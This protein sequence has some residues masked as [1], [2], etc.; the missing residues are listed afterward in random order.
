M[1][2]TPEIENWVQVRHECSPLTMYLRLEKG[3]EEDV[4]TRMEL[5]ES[6]QKVKFWID[7]HE[8]FFNVMREGSGL[9]RDWVQFNLSK[10]SI[11]NR[12]HIGSG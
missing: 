8:N 3:A 11:K 4:K 9:F 10:N 6:D 12:A 7:T 2:T 1:D 5:L